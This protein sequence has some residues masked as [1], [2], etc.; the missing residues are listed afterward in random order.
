MEQVRVDVDRDRD[1]DHD[2]VRLRL[3]TQMRRMGM[4]MLC[5]YAMGGCGRAPAVH[6]CVPRECVRRPLQDATL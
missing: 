3:R 6:I 5:A 4:G 1:H 2:D